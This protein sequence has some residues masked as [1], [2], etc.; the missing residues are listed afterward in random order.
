MAFGSMTQVEAVAA[1]SRADPVGDTRAVPRHGHADA[2]T[3]TGPATASARIR[4]CTVDLHVCDTSNA[5][6]KIK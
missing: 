6:F 4:V 3:V 5:A 2:W 1:A